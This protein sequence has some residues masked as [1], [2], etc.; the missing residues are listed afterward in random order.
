MFDPCPGVSVA[1]LPP[2]PSDEFSDHLATN[3]T[4]E[5]TSVGVGTALDFLGPYTL[6]EYHNPYMAGRI[7]GWRV[8]IASESVRHEVAIDWTQ[9]LEQSD[10]QLGL[11]GGDCAGNPVVVC[12]SDGC[13]LDEN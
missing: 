1:V 8:E 3:I 10:L 2:V 4:V 7:S 5:L 6:S 12:S 13:R 9:D 11:V